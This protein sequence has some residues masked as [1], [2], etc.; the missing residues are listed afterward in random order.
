MVLDCAAT[1]IARSRVG[2]G[3][4]APTAV[5]VLGVAIAWCI[6]VTGGA[7]LLLWLGVRVTGI[8]VTSKRVNPCV[9]WVLQPVMHFAHARYPCTGSARAT[10]GMCMCLC[11]LGMCGVAHPSGPCVA[12]DGRGA[13]LAR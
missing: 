11:G 10:L 1:K 3:D 9:C 8:P 7:H 13:V 12:L 2:V 4:V 6:A 5:E